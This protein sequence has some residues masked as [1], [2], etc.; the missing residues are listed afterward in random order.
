MFIYFGKINIKWL[1]FLL[2]PI[3]ICLV[4]LIEKYLDYE[5]NLFYKSFI[6]FFSRS[7][8]FILWIILYK[9]QKKKPKN[10][11]KEQIIEKY[12]SEENISQNENIIDNDNEKNTDNENINR[13]K[14]NL[15]EYM[16]YKKKIKD[17]KDIKKKKFKAND[18]F[19]LYTIILGFFS[20]TLKYIFSDIKYIEHLSG[21]LIVLTSC[22]RLFICAIC[23]YFILDI[24]IFERH[25]HFSS[26]IIIIVSFIITLLSYFLEDKKNNENFFGKLALVALPE[27]VYC[28]MY[29]VGAIY[30]IKTQGNVYKLIFFNGLFGLIA[31]VVLQF[32]ISFFNCS[33]DIQNLFV[34]DFDICKGKKY[35]TIIENFKSFKKFGGFLTLF[36]IIFNFLK[37]LNIWLL[38][39]YFS[40][41]HF[42]AIYTIPYI[43]L[44]IFQENDFDYRIYYIIG[45]F[46]IILMTLIY[47]EIIILNFCELNKNTKTEITKRANSETIGQLLGSLEETIE[48]QDDEISEKSLY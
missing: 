10:E 3:F 9:S 42:A 11:N 8:S 2:V 30:L 17:N 44:Y 35:K 20:T 37:I 19:L 45:C 31:S 27:I 14:F 40:V 26:A 38:I 34:E 39:Y 21:G 29:I 36:L 23:S 41:N 48:V 13:R 4:Y 5:K 43:L 12:L 28:S 33:K 22:F 18:L 1:L 46:I 7:L 16:L 32:I 25:Q 24:K 15:S 6:K 47:N